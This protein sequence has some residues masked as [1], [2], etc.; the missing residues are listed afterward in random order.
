[1]ERIKLLKNIHHISIIAILEPFSDNTQLQYFRNLLNMDYATHNPNGKIWIFWT[2]DVSC[3]I[4]ENEEQLITCDINHV[5]SPNQ[6]ITTFVYAK[7]KDHL[8]RPLWD[9]MLQ[10]S[11]TSLPWCTVGDFNVITDP[12]EKLGG[13]MYNMRKSLEFISI[14]EAS[15]LQDLGFT[16]QKYTWCNQRGIMSRVWKRLDRGMVNDKWLETMPLTS[17]THLPSVGS[18]HCPLL[19]EMIDQHHNPIKYFKFLNCWPEQPSFMDLVENCWSRS[20]EGNPMWIFH[21]K[22]KR[23]ANTLSNWSR[24]QFGDIHAKVKEYE[25]AVRQAEEDLINRQSNENR[26][27][28]HAI[29]A[30]YIRYMKMENTILRQKTQLQWFKEGD[31]NSSYFHALIRGRRRKLYIHRI[32]T[33]EGSWVQGD[34]EIAEAACEHFQQ[35][36][37]GEENYI[38]QHNLQCIP[39]MVTDQQ[40]ETLQ[41]TPSMEELKTVVFAMNPNS[42]AGPDGMNVNG[43]RHGFFH[44]TRGLKQ[45][46]PLSPAL[47]ILG[48]EVLSRLMNKLHHHPQFHGFYMSQK[49][50]QINHLSFA[51][52]IIIFASG[53]KQ[54]LTLIMETLDTY[55]KTS[56]QLINKHKSHFMIPSN[57]FQSTVQRIKD[58][59]GFTQKSSPI[60]Y[61]GCPIY[62]GRQRI[63]YYSELIAKVVNKI[64]GWQAKILSYGGRVTLVKHVI[65]AMPIHLLAA[66]TPPSTTI[67]Q[68]QSITANF[69]WGW[70][71]DKRKYHWSSWKN[72]SF[73]YDEGA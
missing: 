42:A 68:I 69:F 35:I 21:M 19:M 70:K 7:C 28:L 1:M 33:E 49:G 45:G 59:T 8:R 22:M 31:M 41:A 29:N 18:D 2:K 25:E 39:P 52:D 61:L 63:I 24:N 27:K 71:N 57:A 13:V 43:S 36:F 34:A 12:E 4:L 3:T 6:F 17:I 44:S 55:E 56:G 67:K 72:L 30:E 11:T 53:R 47:F 23:L 54:T 9:S 10:Q 16:G 26:S 65:Q 58:I 32:Q 40:N 66:S 20:I 64:T 38:Q 48:A 14:I 62:I 60:T 5:M 15:G 46:D 37:T 73:P 51:D 50:P